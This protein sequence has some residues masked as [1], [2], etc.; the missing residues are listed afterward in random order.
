[1]GRRA[2]TASFALRTALVAL[3]LIA[4][5]ARSQT[6]VE[7]S[8]SRVFGGVGGGEGV[9]LVAIGSSPVLD[10]FTREAAVT[11]VYRPGAGD[12]DG[13]IVAAF[14]VGGGLRLLRLFS[15]ARSR[16]IP[17]GD[18]DV[19]L[20]VGPS[21]S[22]G[23]GQQSDAQ[24]ARAFAVFADPFVRV[25]RRL[26]G[27]DAFAEIGTQSPVVRVGLSARLGG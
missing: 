17:T 3:A 2:L 16:S 26:R 20:R 23:L 24:R 6:G 22:V 9:G 14:G 5:P 8:G 1:V 10:V 21:F 25:T 19:G 18:L 12:D 27:R 13:R 11:A 4:V 15:L 7:G